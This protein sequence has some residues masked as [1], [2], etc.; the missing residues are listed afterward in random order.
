MKAI[1]GAIAAAVGASICC[2]GP[3]VLSAL[4]AGTLSAAAARFGVYRPILLALTAGL[5]GVAFYATYRGAGCGPDGS[6]PPGS[7]RARTIALWIATILVLLL[8]G[9]PYYADLV[10]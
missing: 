8:V 1:V 6:C 9:F 10:L 7:R 3:V 2:I 5:L 4:G